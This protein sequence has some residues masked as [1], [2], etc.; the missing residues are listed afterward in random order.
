MKKFTLNDFL[1][2]FDTCLCCSKS[3]RLNII[4]STN[5]ARLDMKPIISPNL[6]YISLSIS[7]KETVDLC[8]NKKTNKISSSQGDL[9]KI[10]DY[11]QGKNFYLELGC[12]FCRSQVQSSRIMFDLQKKVMLPISIAF[13]RMVLKE[14]DQTYFLDTNFNEPS[15]KTHVEV[16][17]KD[18]QL[19]FRHDIP[20]YPKYI[21][22]TKE[23]A[24][25]KIKK[26]ISF[27]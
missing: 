5:G 6:I 19:C 20:K 15:S 11:F 12:A 22:K 4:Y 1:D 21:F 10:Q 26:Y 18:I 14:P 13:E 9:S 16:Y 27:Q 23:A 25:K 8:I 7:Y 24:I 2:Y 17:N 3:T